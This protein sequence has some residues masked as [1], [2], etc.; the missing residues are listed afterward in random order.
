MLLILEVIK[1][2]MEYYIEGVNCFLKISNIEIFKNEIALPS[3]TLA[4]VSVSSGS[5]SGAK[6]LKTFL[7]S[8][9]K[10]SHNSL[11][12]STSKGNL[13]TNIYVLHFD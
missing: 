5:F 13:P 4:W 8:F 2:V 7:I 1:K 12:E 3:N 9:I 10:I 6:Q 11:C